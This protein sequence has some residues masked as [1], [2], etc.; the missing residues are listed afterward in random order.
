MGSAALAQEVHFFLSALPEH[1]DLPARLIDILGS[2]HSEVIR[3]EKDTL[4][5]TT[6]QRAALFSLTGVCLSH[7]G[8]PSKVNTALEAVISN[9]SDLATDPPVRRACARGLGK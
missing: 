1:D 4:E 8:V 2:L 6:L 3:K 5:L 7:V 9:Y